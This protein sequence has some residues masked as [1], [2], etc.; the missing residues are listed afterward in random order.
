MGDS[1]K[2]LGLEFR[3][4]QDLPEHMLKNDKE[5]LKIQNISHVLFTGTH[6]EKKEDIASCMGERGKVTLIPFTLYLYRDSVMKT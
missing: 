6:C 2:D 4:R 3:T 1:R 5:E